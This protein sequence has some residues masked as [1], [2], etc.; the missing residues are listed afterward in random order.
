[1]KYNKTDYAQNLLDCDAI[2]Y[3]DALGNTIR[4]TKD[5]FESEEEFMWWK[6]YSDEDYHKIEKTDLAYR[7][8]RISYSFFTE[9]RLQELKTED[10]LMEYI[11]VLE[12]MKRNDLLMQGIHECLTETQLRRLVMYYIGGLDEC[13]I[14]SLEGVGQPRICRS[15]LTAKN[16][17]E[18]FLKN[19]GY[20][21]GFLDNK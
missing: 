2:V 5:D 21:N 19:R 16:K 4:I 10:F 13:Q 20:F 14:A 7:K 6:N 15:I 3:S 12:C 1:M 17:L 8:R 18:K 9:C 11:A